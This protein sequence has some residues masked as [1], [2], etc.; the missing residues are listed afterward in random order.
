AADAIRRPFVERLGT[1]A[2]VEI[3]RS[4]IP[5]ENGPFEASAAAFD[6]EPSEV[7]KQRRTAALSTEARPYVQVLQVKPG[8][9]EKRR[10]VMEEKREA[11]HLGPGTREDNFRRAA[12]EQL[13]S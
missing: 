2:L 1:Q 6:C 12:L 4:L 11:G 7:T 10:E 5:I 13:L 9:A 3:D 8:P